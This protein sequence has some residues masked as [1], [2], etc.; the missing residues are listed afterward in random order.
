MELSDIRIDRRTVIKGGAWAVPV[1][2]SAIAVP[3][4]QTSPAEPPTVTAR[5]DTV[6]G[7]AALTVESTQ[8]G[9]PIPAGVYIFTA[10]SGLVPS[11]DVFRVEPDLG[12]S[13][14]PATA[15]NAFATV[16]LL[17]GHVVSG[18]SAYILTTALPAGTDRSATLTVTLPTG[19]GATVALFEGVSV[20]SP[21][22]LF[23]PDGSHWPARTPRP[24]DTFG[25]VVEVD[26]SWPAIAQAIASAVSAHP[27][28]KVKIA[29]RPGAFAVGRG[30]QSS[31]AGVLANVG[32]TG[33]P[34]RVLVVPR[35]GWGTVTASGSLDTADSQGY[36]FV[37][38]AGIALMG[39]DFTRQAVLLRNST[40]VAIGWSTFGQLNIT[41]NATIDVSDIELVECVLPDQ[42]NSETDRMAFRIAND[43]SISGVRMRGC[44]VAPAYKAGGSS[45]HCDTLQTSRSSGSGTH[46]DL[47]F[48][49]TV[50][51]QSSS[52][53]L[54]FENTSSVTLSH[55]AVL[56]GLRGTDR[57]PLAAGRHVM[58]AENALHARTDD[59]VEGVVAI[60]STLLGSITAWR[61]ASVDD[62]TV[63]KSTSAPVASG[64]FTVDDDYA[65]R[66]APLGEDWYAA[67]C[68]VPSPAR[69]RVIWAG[70]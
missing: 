43:F 42:V 24:D 65:D 17:E 33:R 37:G 15:A 62:T 12:V 64:A 11:A 25:S 13:V 14:Q 32:A 29:V 26:A 47:S 58:T 34:W 18:F 56:G 57:Y 9:R 2:A 30:A 35:D 22:G 55:V 68:P 66:T 16:T 60:R 5:P 70:I 54:M 51:F 38:I 41:A 67:N 4:A 50:F 63:S 49:D 69:L 21:S 59:P 46:R 36:A 20:P 23:G 39:F 6:N 19:S 10:S 53:V 1:V 61:F 28:G 27:A 3:A 45:S 44:Y 40:D 52:Q 8:S 48:E 31:D 7:F